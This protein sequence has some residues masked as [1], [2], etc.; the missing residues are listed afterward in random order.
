MSDP[1]P[2]C[3]CGERSRA[4]I[5]CGECKGT[6]APDVLLVPI[7]VYHDLHVAALDACVQLEEAYLGQGNTGEAVYEKLSKLLAQLPEP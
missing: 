5:L 7:A 3:T 1:D 2:R 6:L 4:S